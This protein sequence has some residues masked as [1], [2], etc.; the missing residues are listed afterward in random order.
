MIS[1]LKV[2]LSLIKESFSLCIMLYLLEKARKQ[3]LKVPYMDW[4][5][6]EAAGLSFK[7]GRKPP[8]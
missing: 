2:G 5:P 6:G 1:G 4:N 3:P 8:I 7:M